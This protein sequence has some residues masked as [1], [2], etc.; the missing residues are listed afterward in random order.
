MRISFLILLK[1]LKTKFPKKNEIIFL[2]YNLPEMPNVAKN[3]GYKL[4]FNQINK[5]NWFFNFDQLNKQI[6][7]KTLAI[8]L[9]N[10][11][12]S[13]KETFILKKFAKKIKLY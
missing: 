7:H 3:L 5:K 2:D 9:T 13:P 6:N 11:F 8:V 4:V 1:Y 10:M 12:N